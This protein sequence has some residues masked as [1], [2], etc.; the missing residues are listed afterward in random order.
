MRAFLR[1]NT[2][3]SIARKLQIAIV[4]FPIVASPLFAVP[5]SAASTNVR[6]SD[7]NHPTV[8]A[9]RAPKFPSID[10]CVAPPK[11]PPQTD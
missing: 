3:G 9:I 7:A 5:A 11:L 1:T 2:G 10:L 4:A 8:C 6:G